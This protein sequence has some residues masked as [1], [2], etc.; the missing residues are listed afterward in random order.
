[1]TPSAWSRRGFLGGFAAGTA[2][3]ASGR[4]S[5]FGEASSVDIAEL[6]LSSGTLSRPE[7]WKRLLYEVI[8]TTSVE[9][10]PRSVQLDPEDPALFAHPFAVLVGDDAF[11]PLSEAALQQLGRYLSYGG[12]LLVDDASGQRESAF[13]RSVRSLASRLFPTRPLTLLRSDHSV[14][15]SFFL[16]HEP[17]GRVANVRALEGVPQGSTHVFV[18]CRDDLS[19]ALDRR[20]DGVDANACVPGGEAQRREAVKLGINLIMYALTSNYK[21]DIT[22]VNELLREGRLE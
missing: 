5:A 16:L 10:V 19:G 6:R 8:Q 15:R 7:A 11:P 4:A 2:A 20:A 18:Y 14:Y 13:D 1:M 22:H 9:A 3:L 21:Q 17:L 12:F